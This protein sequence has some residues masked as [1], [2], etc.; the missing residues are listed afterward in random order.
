MS[1]CAVAL[2]VVLGG[3]VESSSIKCGDRVC[4][5]D[6]LCVELTGGAGD[7]HRCVAEDAITACSGVLEL[8]ACSA[9]ACYETTTGLVCLASGCGNGLVDSNEVCDDGNANVGDGCSAACLSDE[10]CGNGI[11]DGLR[12]D[13]EGTYGPGELCDDGNLVGH[14]GC[15][16][17]CEDERPAWTD[18]TPAIPAPRMR[19]AMTFD[20]IRRR[21][22][23]VGGHRQDGV[24]QGG[25]LEAPLPDLWENDGRQWVQRRPTDAPSARVGTALAFDAEH[26]VAVLF[27]GLDNHARNDLWSWDGRRWHRLAPAASPPGRYRH[28]LAYDGRRHVLVVFGGTDEQDMHLGDTWE[29]DG[30]TWTHVLLAASPSAREAT[31]AYDPVRGVVVMVGAPATG[32][33]Y[34]TWEYDGVSW[35]QKAMFAT[36]APVAGGSAP[37]SLAFDA[38]SSRILALGDATSGGNSTFSWDGTSWTDLASGLPGDYQGASLAETP[39]GH[40]VLF[41]GQ[42]TDCSGIACIL[43]NRNQTFVWNAASWTEQVF[44]GPAPR[45]FASAVLDPRRR[46]VVVVGGF[47]NA[48][49]FHQT[50]EYDGFSWTAVQGQPWSSGRC[51]ASIAYDEAHD[52]IVV[53]GG[54]DAGMLNAETWIRSGQTWANPTPGQSPPARV[55]GAMAYD[56][57]RRQAVLFGGSDTMTDAGIT[58]GDTWVWDGTSWTMVTP[59]HSP[60]DRRGA[61]IAWDPILSQLVL[62][63][64]Q[65]RQDGDSSSI[66]LGDTWTW[67]GSDWT[68]RVTPQ[69]PSARRL[70][71]LALD[72]T[73][74]RLVLFG[75]VDASA[76]ASDTWEWDGAGWRPLAAVDRPSP[77]LGHAM[78]G[79]PDGAGLVMIGG[80]SSA[81]SLA[82]NVETVALQ[83]TGDVDYESCAL[84]LDLDGDALSGCADP[85]CWWLC[86]PTCPPETSCDAMAPA[87][88]DG[89]CSALED[90]RTCPTDCTTCP[91]RCGD[92]VCDPDETAAACPGDCAP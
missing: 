89:A 39:D 76:S 31:M 2:L 75:G 56:P 29:W 35:T 1:R 83:W 28:G 26:K 24:P 15:T 9:G 11:V 33:G 5:H 82:G 91:D 74:G 51:A 58:F 66:D 30:T 65:R 57:V 63:G 4:P 43:A 70:A 46:V 34:E 68:E 64:G 88:G 78:A 42:Y 8:E 7:P 6:T 47:D 44:D 45:Y 52:Q 17:G 48:T 71:A 55:H 79:A 23:M 61:V 27:G 85:D 12:L 18:V 54:T 32:G 72:A 84:P 40:V 81:L 38:A 41:G 67:D 77:R 19:A 14:D 21:V 53:F 36:A 16:S 80:T 73:R 92:A 50:L 60:S 90:C 10:T 86:T 87:C 69:A 62:F 49:M 20:P 59:V 37:T 22:V 3:C 25:G 13:S